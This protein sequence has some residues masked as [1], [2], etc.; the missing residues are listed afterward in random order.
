[1]MIDPLIHTRAPIITRTHIHTLEVSDCTLIYR[2]RTPDANMIPLQ[3]AKALT[4]G[5]ETRDEA[6]D[7]VELVVH[8]KSRLPQGSL[9]S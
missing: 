2:T 5:L 4:D 7:R 6:D 3:V 1:M 8:K 9:E